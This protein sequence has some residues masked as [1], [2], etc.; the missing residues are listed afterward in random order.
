[1]NRYYSL[2]YSS[3]D[4]LISVVTTTKPKR[5]PPHSFPVVLL[6]LEAKPG[7]RVLRVADNAME[8]MPRYS[9]VR[10]IC[11]ALGITIPRSLTDKPE[12]RRRHYA[13]INEARHGRSE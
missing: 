3:D 5:Y 9:E 1:M 13:R 2:N 6:R 12:A 10:A 11:A 4:G 7:T 8:Y